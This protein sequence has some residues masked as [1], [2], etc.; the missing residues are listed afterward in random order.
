MISN[1]V[2]QTTSLHQLLSWI[3]PINFKMA[4]TEDYSKEYL[5]KNVKPKH[6]SVALTPNLETF[7][8]EGS[9]QIS[10]VSHPLTLFCFRNMSQLVSQWN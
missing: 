7:T 6:Y 8:F 1:R 10:Y 3:I 9:V 5:P 2:D 4:V